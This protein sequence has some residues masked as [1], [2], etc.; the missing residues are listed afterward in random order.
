MNRKYF[1]VEVVILLLL[2]HV[3]WN[4]P[5]TTIMSCSRS[6]S[7]LVRNVIEKKFIPV[8]D[9]YKVTLPLDC[10]FHKQR[11]VFWWPEKNVGENERWICPA[12]TMTFHCED[13]LINHWDAMHTAD[14][15]K[16]TTLKSIFP[17]VIR[18]CTLGLLA[19]LSLK[20]FHDIEDE[21]NKVVCSYLTCDRFWDDSLQDINQ[22]P[23]LFCLIIGLIMVGGF[24][25]CYY[26]VWIL[27]DSS[28]YEEIH[29]N[30]L[31]FP[32]VT[33][34][35]RPS[36]FPEYRYQRFRNNNRFPRR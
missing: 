29:C 32:N 20:D 18:Q 13:S 2:S 16:L 14:R 24:C 28:P 26:I 8:L 35:P 17:A 22:V 7:R 6:K 31:N 15:S 21:L 33:C 5:S 9:R 19:T 36:I 30:G 4:G 12:C 3:G 27:F 34:T 10:P 23:I 1:C 25:L 11:D